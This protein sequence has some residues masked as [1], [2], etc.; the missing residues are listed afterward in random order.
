ML[1]RNNELVAAYRIR[2]GRRIGSA[3]LVADGL[4]A[5]TDGFTSLAVVIG[6]AGVAAG[7]RPADPVAG[8]LICIAIFGVPRPY[9]TGCCTTS[10]GSPTPPFTSARCRARQPTRTNRHA[11]TS[12]ARRRQASH[13][14]HEYPNARPDRWWKHT[15]RVPV[16][17]ATGLARIGVRAAA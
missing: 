2:V 14:P 6:A 4:H 10:A 17:A 8:I 11:I 15:G 13:R 7:W 12:M 5:R 3:A 9:R 1:S 16:M